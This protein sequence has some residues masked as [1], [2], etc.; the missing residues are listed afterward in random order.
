LESVVGHQ[1]RPVRVRLNLGT[2]LN[3]LREGPTVFLGG[4]D[5]QW[6]LKLIE[7]LR[8]QFGGSDVDSFYIRDSKDPGNRQWSLHLQD[9]MAT[10]NRDYAI[11][12]R[13]HSQVLGQVIVIVAGIGMSGTAAAGEFLSNPNQV[14][15][16]ERRIGSDS[17]RDF[18]AVLTTD[19]DNGIAG[20]ARI[21]AVDVRQ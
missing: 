8:Y 1:N 21:V 4:L 17:D 3:E 14:A 19:V 12:A 9:K 5:N 20:P 18:E 16:L 10:V 6:T 15:E 7:P 13:I 2:N 11:I